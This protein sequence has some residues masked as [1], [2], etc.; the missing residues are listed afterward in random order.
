MSCKYPQKWPCVFGKVILTIQ[1]EFSFQALCPSLGGFYY[2]LAT[3]LCSGYVVSEKALI[4]E[5]PHLQVINQILTCC[6][7]HF[8]TI[9]CWFPNFNEKCRQELDSISANSIFP[10]LSCLLPNLS[11]KAYCKKLWNSSAVSVMLL[12]KSVHCSH[13]ESRQSRMIKGW[14]CFIL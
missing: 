6:I 5:L 13:S 1:D 10:C 8:W 3:V 9:F 7:R 14:A 12:L 11:K 4:S 2:L